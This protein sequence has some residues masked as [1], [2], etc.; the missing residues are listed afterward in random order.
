MSTPLS[1]PFA[2]I[3]LAMAALREKK[4]EVARP[5]LKELVAEFPENP[6]VASELAKPHVPPAAPIPPEE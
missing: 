4:T 1:P 2:K 6:L 5:Q 3:I